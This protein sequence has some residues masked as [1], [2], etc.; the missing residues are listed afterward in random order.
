MIKKIK[1]KKEYFLAF[2]VPF[3][4]FLLLSFALGFLLKRDNNTVYISDMYAQYKALFMNLKTEGLHLY[5]FSKGLGSSMIGTYAYYL[6]SPLNWIIFLFQES[7][8]PI[9]ILLIIGFKISLCSLTMYIYLKHHSKET[10]LLL[11][12]SLCYAFMAFNINYFFNIMWLD[13]VYLLPLVLLGI[14]KIVKRKQPYLYIITLFV[15]VLTNY[16]MAFMVC[17]FSVIYFI[18]QLYLQYSYPLEKEKIWKIVKTFLISSLLGGL[19]ASFL[20][21]PTALEFKDMP[22]GEYNA[23]TENHLSLNGNPFEIIGKMFMGSQN[24]DSLLAKQN[25]HVYAGILIFIL[26]FLYFLNHKISKKEKKAS[27]VIL[28]IFILSMLVN[29][30]NYI[31]HGFNIPICFNGRYIFI[32]SCFMIYLAFQSFSKIQ[33]ITK[34]Q[35]FLIA[36]IFPILGVITFLGQ[37]IF[38]NTIL[39]FAS[40]FL[41][42]IYI[43]LLYAYSREEKQALIA[44]LLLVLVSSEL[45]SNAFFSLQ[46][47]SFKYQKET[48]EI[49]ALMKKEIGKMEKR[50]DSLFYRFEKGFNFSA[51]DPLYLG[52]KGIG[53]F[54]STMS[55]TQL[56]FLSNLGYN[57]HNNLIEYLAPVPVSD[58]LFG[59]K[60]YMEKDGEVSYYD[61][62]DTFK[63]SSAGGTFYNVFQTDVNV[64]KNPYALE[65]GTLVQNDVSTCI[66]KNKDYDRLA[67]QNEVIKCLTGNNQDIY[68]KIP[69]KKVEGTKYT[70]TN[71]KNYDFFAYPNVKTNFINNEDEVELFINGISLGNYTNSFFTMQFFENHAEQGVSM[72]VETKNNKESKRKYNPYVYYFN[73]DAYRDIFSQLQQNSLKIIKFKNHYL[74]GK[75]NVTKENH[76]LF[77]TIPYDKGWTIHVDGKKIKYDK[78]FDTFIGFDLKE[79]THKITFSYWPPGLTLG[80]ILSS[81]SLFG[82]IFFMYSFKKQNG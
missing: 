7:H 6:V 19:L 81:M 54:L 52:Y 76:Y 17:I 10:K 12:F 74:E 60:Y 62:I 47:Y 18:Y 63:I 42:F 30:F 79:G 53:T 1:N 34:K 45:F 41:S 75:A 31:W 39:V 71:T 38:T 43:F 73:T 55:K 4:L 78:V 64:Y 68:E 35:Y 9:A 3:L 5:S 20:I 16:Y 80:F 27:F 2:I 66:P 72:E 25:F 56:D 15:T 11:L 36:P 49:Y 82:C 44:L 21:I 67:Y 50:E 48:E 26:V 46:D 23:F 77:T 32:F 57:T 24:E 70:F 58:A 29:Y 40:V 22:R 59:V 37:F 8:L 65:L 14:D 51:N 69:L 61:K 33:Y 13:S 28:I